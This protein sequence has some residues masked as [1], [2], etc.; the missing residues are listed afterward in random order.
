MIADSA[1]Q[2]LK[3]VP[4][5]NNIIC[6]RIKKIADDINNQLVTNV[7]RNEFSLQIDDAQSVQAIKMLTSFAKHDLLIKI[8]TLLKIYSS[9]RSF[10]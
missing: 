2:E 8:A 4:L 7:H 6:K 5:S 9:A 3:T 1:A 10:Y